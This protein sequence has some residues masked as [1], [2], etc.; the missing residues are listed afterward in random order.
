M[1]HFFLLVVYFRNYCSISHVNVMLIGLVYFRRCLNVFHVNVVFGFQSILQEHIFEFY[2]FYM[3]IHN[4]F[5][6]LCVDRLTLLM[7]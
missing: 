7:M 4:I 5:F 2:E 1:D 6:L 3:H